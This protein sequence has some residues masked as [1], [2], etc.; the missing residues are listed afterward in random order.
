MG[1]FDKSSF[2]RISE[3]N[4]RRSSGEILIPEFQREF[5]WNISNICELMDSINKGFPIGTLLFWDYK[6]KS[7][8]LDGVQRITALAIALSPLSEFVYDLEKDCFWGHKGT[9]TSTIQFPLAAVYSEELFDDWRVEH[10]GKLTKEL[11]T[12]L[13]NFRYAV[14]DALIPTQYLKT[15]DPKFAVEY[16]CRL[17]VSGTTLTYTDLQKAKAWGENL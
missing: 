4:Q 3:I 7:Y 13:R 15:D 9:S 1:L 5:V 17:N 10:K 11:K 14:I 16:F 12:R 2:V 6:G 8:I